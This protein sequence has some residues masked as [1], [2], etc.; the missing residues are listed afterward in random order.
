MVN[1]TIIVTTS[2]AANYFFWGWGELVTSRGGGLRELVTS[3]GGGVRELVMEN[4]E[5]VREKSGKIFCQVC[6]NPEYVH[7]VHLSLTTQV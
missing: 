6:G 5:M 4:Q 7:R 2:E 3:R 1:T